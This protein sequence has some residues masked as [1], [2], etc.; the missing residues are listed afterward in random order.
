MRA[1][2]NQ[3]RGSERDEFEDAARHLLARNAAGEP[4]GVGRI[5]WN[6]DEQAQI[7]YMATRDDQ[8]GRGVGASIIGRLEQIARERGTRTIVINA[9][10]PA[11]PFYE[12]LGYTVIGDG[13]TLYGVIPHKRMRRRL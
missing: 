8:R 13:V 12:K 6:S 4:S 11:V 7:R 3:P 1:P 2:W 9:R 5:H 10:A